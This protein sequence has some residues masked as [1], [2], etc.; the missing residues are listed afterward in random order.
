MLFYLMQCIYQKNQRLEKT[1]KKFVGDVKKGNKKLEK[2]LDIAEYSVLSSDER[3]EYEDSLKTYNDRKNSLDTAENKGY[4][5]AEELFLPQIEEAKAR[6]LE[7]RR[8]KEEER[9]QKEE[10]LLKQEEAQQKLKRIIS[11]MLEKGFSITEI[12]DDLGM[13]ELEILA[14]LKH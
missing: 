12:A 4:L 14:I 6:E 11:K 2:V 10:A 7:E 3:T 1:K 5:K 13:T 9:R 8:Q